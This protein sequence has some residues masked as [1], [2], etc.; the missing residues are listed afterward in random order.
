MTGFFNSWHVPSSETQGQIV[1]ARESLNGRK[2]MARRKV[3]NGEKSPWGQCLTRPGPNGRRRYAFLDFPSPPLS[4]PGSPRMDMYQQ[5]ENSS[6]PLNRAPYIQLRKVV[7][8]YR[9]LYGGTQVCAPTINYKVFKISRVWDALSPLVFN[10]SIPN[11]AT[12]SNLSVI[13]PEESTD[14]F[15]LTCP[16]TPLNKVETTMERSIT[17]Q[18]ITARPFFFFSVYTHSWVPVSSRHNHLDH[19]NLHKNRSLK[20]ENLYNFCI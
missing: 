2:N 15:S 8:M 11:F 10:K 13:F 3:K 12:F 1:G 6:K 17:R 9:R 7:K 18:A 4:A 19:F 14:V 5:L 20:F 16:W